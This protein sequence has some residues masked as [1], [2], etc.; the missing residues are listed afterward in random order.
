M[1]EP[2]PNSG[3]PAPTPRKVYQV[4]PFVAPCRDLSPSAPFEWLRLGWRDLR[5]APGL[6]L[7]WGL[8]TVLA[9]AA[10]AWLAWVIGRWVLLI[11]VLS[12]FIF[13]APL[14]AFAL[15]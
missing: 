1:S 6:S 13:V 2:S 5:R 15:Y 12:G 3:T 11:S 4:K 14:M 9:F 8:I 7:A 10:V